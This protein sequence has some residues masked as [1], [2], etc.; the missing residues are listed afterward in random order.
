MESGE[1]PKQD[2]MGDE[3]NPRTVVEDHLSGANPDNMPPGTKALKTSTLTS[4]GGV[5]TEIQEEFTGGKVTQ[6]VINLDERGRQ[7][8]KADDQA[9]RRQQIGQGKR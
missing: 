6:T 8:A 5:R 1:G 4:I 2:G 7:L 9:V 3:I